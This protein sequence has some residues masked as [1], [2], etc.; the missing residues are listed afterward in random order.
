M[1][2]SRAKDEKLLSLH[3]FMANAPLPSAVALT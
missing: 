2:C 3:E 1:L